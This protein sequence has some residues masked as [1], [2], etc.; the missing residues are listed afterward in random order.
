MWLLEQKLQSSAEEAGDHLGTC[1]KLH[2][3]RIAAGAPGRDAGGTTNSGAVIVF[4]ETSG[5]WVESGSYQSGSPQ[6]F[7]EYGTSVAMDQDHLLVGSPGED[8]GDGAAYLYDRLSS[9]WINEQRLSP[10]NS[11]EIGLFGS[12]V[13]LDVRTAAIGIPLAGDDQGNVCLLRQENGVWSP[14][15]NLI[16]V[17]DQEIGDKFGTSIS[18][19]IPFLLVG[20]AGEDSGE[21]VWISAFT[22]CNLNLE[23]DVCD[24]TQGIEPDCNLNRIPDSCEIEDG[25]KQDCDEN[26]VP[27]ECQI[28][29]GTLPDCNLNGVPD[30]CDISSGFSLDCNIDNLPDECQEDAD[31]F[32]PVISNMPDPISVET[33]LDQC[34]AVVLWD[35]PNAIDDCGMDSLESSQQPGDFFTPGLSIVTYTA[36]DVSGNTTTA[37]FTVLVNDEQAPGLEGL[38]NL[39]T[40]QAPIDTCEAPAS[41]NVPQPTDNCGIFSMSSSHSPG[42]TFSVGLTTVTYTVMDLSGNVSEFPFTVEV[43]DNHL[44]EIVGIPETISTVTDPGLCTAV[45]EWVEPIPEDDCEIVSF[46]STHTNGGVFPVG[47]TVVSY[48]VIDSSGL[49][50]TETFTINVEDDQAPEF[51]AVPTSTSL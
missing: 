47:S 25:T 44:P 35:A 13:S 46:L 33:D 20:C 24:V 21:S 28:A 15:G 2:D 19:Q 5:L 39:V 37:M 23:D 31:P 6:A 50:T 43:L 45:V 4:E 41:W 32:H 51:T 1:V 49:E 7:G 16:S 3:G 14:V 34:G 38:T 27:D 40:V 42:S 36:T 10:T 22:D 48:T 17:G 18:C 29:D 8:A 30:D 9:M 11:D 12:S 26:G